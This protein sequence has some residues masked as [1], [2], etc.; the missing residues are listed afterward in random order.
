M[1]IPWLSSHWGIRRQEIGLGIGSAK[2]KT[3]GKSMKIPVVDL[4]GLAFGC[5]T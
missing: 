3:I 2:K 5:F 1:I 4:M